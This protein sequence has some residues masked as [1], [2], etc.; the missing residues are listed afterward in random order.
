MTEELGVASWGTTLLTVLIA[1]SVGCVLA[2]SLIAPRPP[3]ELE[4]AGL[5]ARLRKRK[6]RLLRAMKDCAF[7]LQSGTISAE[8]YQALRNDLKER[9]IQATRDIERVR[10]ARFKSLLSR[11]RGVVP[12]SQRKHLEALIAIRREKLGEAPVAPAKG[13]SV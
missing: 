13:D 5:L 4:S 1:I 10:R 2:Y 11:G 12:P 8:G 3:W 9:A 6:D 7:E